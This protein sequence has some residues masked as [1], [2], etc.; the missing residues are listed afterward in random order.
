MCDCIPTKN[1]GKG[2]C[3]A[4]IGQQPKTLSYSLSF[5]PYPCRCNSRPK[6]EPPESGSVPKMRVG[7]ARVRARVGLRPLGPFAAASAAQ[8]CYLLFMR[9]IR[10]IRVVLM[11]SPAFSA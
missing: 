7:P 10:L 1:D 8:P 3:A 2:G 5:V 9:L 4:A 11:N 6:L